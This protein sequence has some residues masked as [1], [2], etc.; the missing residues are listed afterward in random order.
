LRPRVRAFDELDECSVRGARVEEGDAVAAG[1]GASDWVDERNLGGSQLRQGLL[2]VGYREGDVVQA[3]AAL[4]EEFFEAGVGAGGGHELDGRARVGQVDES[5]FDVK[6][7]EALLVRQGL[8]EETGP[9]PG[10]GVDGLDA[11][12]DVVDAN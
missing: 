4:G 10:R 11:D 9:E 6:R 1:A 5:G 12:A 2:D 3:G 8:A 7:G